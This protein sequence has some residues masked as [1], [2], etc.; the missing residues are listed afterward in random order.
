MSDGQPA[1]E[2]K[3][4]VMLGVPAYGGLSEG[5]AAGAYRA[6]GR[7]DTKVLIRMVNNS[8]LAHS[9]NLL[10][11]RAL[12]TAKAEGLGY[13]AMMHSDIEPPL[14][15][16]DALIDELE[17]KNLDVLGVAV[18][19]KDPRGLTSTAVARDD[20]DTF[21]THCRLS[22]AE[23]HRLPE[24]FTSDDL[25]GRKL[26]LNTGLWVCR[27]GDW[28]PNLFFTIND[29]III[30]ADGNYHAAVEP[31]DWFASRLFH[32]MGLKVGCTRKLAVNHRGHQPYPNN[33]VWGQ[34]KHDE[35]HVERSILD[36]L[37]AP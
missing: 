33:L 37:P 21:R 10:W 2:Y 32:E 31:E 36:E 4:K 14:G 23:I 19:I 18:A 27:H 24:T 11:C 12:N 34:W 6:N 22:M 7:A 28:W 13:F 9:F 1:T 20:G 30:G 29:K 16:V 26:L 3:R 35:S 15:W 8:L 17:A 25:G 5:A